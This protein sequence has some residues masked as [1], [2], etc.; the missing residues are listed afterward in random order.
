MKNILNR[1]KVIIGCFGPKNMVVHDNDNDN[2]N[3]NNYNDE[4][5]NTVADE[6]TCIE[7][8]CFFLL[9]MTRARDRQVKANITI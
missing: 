4:N 8:K 2:N 1:N 9:S 5:N 7:A 3:D 6:L